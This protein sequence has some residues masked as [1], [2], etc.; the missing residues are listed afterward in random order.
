MSCAWL[1]EKL[2]K[3]NLLMYCKEKNT[4]W[5]VCTILFRLKHCECV[6]KQLKSNLFR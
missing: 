3:T 1:A 5:N 6:I 2:K 4:H